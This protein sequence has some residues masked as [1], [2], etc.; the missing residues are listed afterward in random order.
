M[1]HVSFIT[2]LGDIAIYLS[3]DNIDKSHTSEVTKAG[4]SLQYMRDLKVK[5]C[6][7]Y[8]FA[9]FAVQFWVLWEKA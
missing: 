8:I 7:L 9:K 3:I 2:Y 4:G 1:I 6:T 5:Y